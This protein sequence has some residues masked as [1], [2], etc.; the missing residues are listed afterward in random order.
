MPG[1]DAKRSNHDFTRLTAPTCRALLP[2]TPA[3]LAADL[4]VSGRAPVHRRS[5]ALV[6]LSD[7]LCGYPVTALDYVS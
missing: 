3:P 5:A 4:I 2:G 6:P 7:W 1:T